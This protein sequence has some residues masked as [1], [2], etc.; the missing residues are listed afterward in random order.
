MIYT[1]LHAA[2]KADLQYHFKYIDES[3]AKLDLENE[4]YSK[5]DMYAAE[6]TKAYYY[7]KSTEDELKSQ[8]IN[9]F[10][11]ITNERNDWV[12]II[13]DYAGDGKTDLINSIVDKI[14]DTGGH[15]GL[16]SIR[17]YTYG[18]SRKERPYAELYD[19]VCKIIDDNDRLREELGISDT[20]TDDDFYKSLSRPMPETTVLENMRLFL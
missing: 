13:F 18:I 7:Y 20:D 5:A 15:H 9:R 19:I 17:R 6:F 16:H 3:K 4:A 11:D 14:P 1:F 2:R 12:S 10:R 8:L